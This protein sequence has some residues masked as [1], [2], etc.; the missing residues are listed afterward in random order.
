[1]LDCCLSACLPHLNPD[2]PCQSK[3]VSVLSRLP[4]VTFCHC[5]DNWQCAVD[6][7]C[8]CQ[9]VNCLLGEE[10]FDIRSCQCHDICHSVLGCCHSFESCHFQT[11]PGDVVGLD[12]SHEDCHCQPCSIVE[13]GTIGVGRSQT[14]D[15]WVLDGQFVED[16]EGPSTGSV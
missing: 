10:I 6:R 3:G 13:D 7:R 14:Q 12:I 16:V 8:H 5:H 1:M 15:I 2:C 9:V 11:L 4:C